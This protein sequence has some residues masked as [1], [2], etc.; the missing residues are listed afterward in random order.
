MRLRTFVVVVSAP[1]ILSACGTA[2]DTSET[3]NSA[4]S[5]ASFAQTAGATA[6][7]ATPTTTSL[8]GI[9]TRTTPCRRGTATVSHIIGKTMTYNNLGGKAVPEV[10]GA[11]LYEGAH[12]GDEHVEVFV[13][14]RA[15]TPTATASQDSAQYGSACE[16]Q[17]TPRGGYVWCPEEEEARSFF[18]VLQAIGSETYEVTYIFPIF[19]AYRGNKIPTKAEMERPTRRLFNVFHP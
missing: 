7:S 3:S 5:S 18:T 2:T 10:G 17:V 8:S 1:L 13:A 11:C 16:S 9:A 6:T 19:N 12:E 4:A 14:T 15:G